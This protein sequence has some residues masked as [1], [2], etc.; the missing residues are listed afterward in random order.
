LLRIN[1]FAR[2]GGKIDEYTSVNGSYVYE[3]IKETEKELFQIEN[4]QKR[5]GIL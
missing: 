5:R 4:G 3:S 1:D 2:K